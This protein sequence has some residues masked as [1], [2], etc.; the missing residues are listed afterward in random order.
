M[1]QQLGIMQI[2]RHHANEKILWDKVFSML[3]FYAATSYPFNK[4]TMNITRVLV[5]P[6]MD[7][8]PC[9]ATWLL[10]VALMCSKRTFF[11]SLHCDYSSTHTWDCWSLW[12]WCQTQAY[13]LLQANFPSSLFSTLDPSTSK[14]A[15]SLPNNFNPFI[16]A[17]GWNW[18][19]RAYFH[20]FLRLPTFL[21]NIW[22]KWFEL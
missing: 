2:Q 17:I 16:G 18:Q 14:V 19:F 11:C 4:S 8:W 6:I 15:S 13:S 22:W 3:L 1:F 9:L 5:A 7:P 20:L 10:D 21:H 12:S